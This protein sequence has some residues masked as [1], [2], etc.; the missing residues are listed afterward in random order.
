VEA[1]MSAALAA[2]RA[3]LETARV[4]TA[5]ATGSEVSERSAELLAAGRPPGRLTVRLVGLSAA[6]LPAGHRGRY[7]EE[8]SSLL[9]E[10]GTRRSRA[11]QV[12]SILAGAP[13][14][15]WALRHPLKETPPA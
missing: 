12:V 6:M 9:F 13:R 11:R 8:W 5:L 2:E 10:L 15:A 3:L 1:A 4:F 7:T 14:Q